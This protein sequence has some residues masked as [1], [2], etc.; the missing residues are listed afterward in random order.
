MPRSEELYLLDIVASIDRLNRYVA[1][2]S[3]DEFLADEL[4]QD[5]VVRRLEIVGESA[6]HLSAELRARHATVPWSAIIGFRNVAIHG[7]FSINLSTVW[8]TATEDV[9]A[10]GAVVQAI[11]DQEF[12]APTPE[13][14]E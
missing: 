4:L 1:D 3:F 7:Y 6:A 8:T 10:L 11:L 14:N 9:A 13:P 5:G 2:R 12:Q